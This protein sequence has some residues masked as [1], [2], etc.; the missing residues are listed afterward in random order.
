MCRLLIRETPSARVVDYVTVAM[1]DRVAT[2]ECEE[3]V[4]HGIDTL[5]VC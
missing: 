1:E 2:E 3:D 5:K 4:S